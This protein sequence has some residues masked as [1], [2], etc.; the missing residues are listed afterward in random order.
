MSYVTAAEF[1]AYSPSTVI[2]V[3]EF[4]ELAE[5]AS[6]IIDIITMNKIEDAGGITGFVA[7]I[8]AKIKKATCAQIQTMYAAGGADVVT[9][10]GGEPQSVTLSKFS[11]T[12]GESKAD[13]FNGIPI[14]PMANVYLHGTGLLYRGLALA[15]P[16]EF[17]SEFE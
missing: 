6:E 10:S 12:A 16:P 7:A 15:P 11:Y 13:T 5:R 3:G 8:Q 17:G 2:P 1:T 14:A 4:A 9:G